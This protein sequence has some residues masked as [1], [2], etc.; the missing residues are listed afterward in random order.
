MNWERRIVPEPSNCWTAAKSVLDAASKQGLPLCIDLFRALPADLDPEEAITADMVAAGFAN[1]AGFDVE[2]QG[3]TVKP[4]LYEIPVEGT[5]CGLNVGD[6]QALAR[7]VREPHQEFIR[8]LYPESFT[9]DEK[10][11]WT[12]GLGTR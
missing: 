7:V 8:H 3:K 4:F 2:T 9:E 1:L 5:R 6:F 11:G 10:N 12:S